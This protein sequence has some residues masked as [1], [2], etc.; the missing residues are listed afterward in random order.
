MS[1]LKAVD[2]DTLEQ[3]LGDIDAI[4]GKAVKAGAA[5]LGVEGASCTR[6]T[7]PACCTQVL[8]AFVAEVI[9]L[10]HHLRK[11]GKDTPDLRKRL[12]SA[13]AN[14]EGTAQSPSLDSKTPCVFL[15][16]KRCSIYP[17]RPARCRSYFVFSE[18]KLCQPPSGRKV[19]FANY[20]TA[21]HYVI[22]MA[23]KTSTRLSLKQ[24]RMRILVGSFPR[25][26]LITLE[27]M[28]DHVE[29]RKHI[30]RQPWPSVNNY[31]EWVDGTVPEPALVRIRATR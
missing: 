25:V 21:D 16:E 13:A 27:G 29:F 2:I 24:S 5:T 23:K 26:V 1:K 14:L 6:C 9:P 28:D 19:E 18:P 30:R 15:E 10:A 12:A 3:M 11:T 20:A 4:M 22:E 17:L 7:E 8:F 31:N